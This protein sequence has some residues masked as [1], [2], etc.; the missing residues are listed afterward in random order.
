MEV[1]DISQKFLQFTDHW[2]PKI[3]AQMNDNHIKLVKIQGEFIWHSHP[4]TDE[5]F[6][7]V[8]GAMGIHLRDKDVKLKAGQICVVPKGVEHKPYAENECHVMLIEPA[9][10]VNTGDRGGEYTAST[11]EWI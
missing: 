11:E 3:I 6:V 8:E 2:S 1:I 5:V 7:V 9:G 10:T 4:D